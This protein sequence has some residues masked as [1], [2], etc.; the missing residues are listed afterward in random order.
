M[1]GSAAV[2]GL[3]LGELAES[4]AENSPLTPVA[5]R[6]ICSTGTDDVSTAVVLP[7]RRP[8]ENKVNEKW[9]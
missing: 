5:G 9:P 1:N 4:T 2:P 8:A 6:H 3:K 7:S